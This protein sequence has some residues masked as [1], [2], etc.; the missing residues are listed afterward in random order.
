MPPPAAARQAE[1]GNAQGDAGEQGKEEDEQQQHYHHHH[2]DQQQQ[3]GCH[4]EEAEVRE[5]GAVEGADLLDAEEP[6][7]AIGGAVALAP[8]R[9]PAAGRGG[10]CVVVYL[11]VLNL[12]F[13]V[14]CAFTNRSLATHKIQTKGVQLRLPGIMKTR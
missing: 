13:V 6:A 7:V 4:D 9:P 3:W 5:E 12:E 2:H 11:C 10:C 8:A 1:E 14:L